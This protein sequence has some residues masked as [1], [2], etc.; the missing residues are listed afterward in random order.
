[1]AAM[2]I[3]RHKSPGSWRQAADE[4]VQLGHGGT[5]IKFGHGGSFLFWKADDPDPGQVIIVR[6]NFIQP[7]LHI[8]VRGC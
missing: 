7:L 5:F 2:L 4:L 8:P 1:M 3:A 6:G